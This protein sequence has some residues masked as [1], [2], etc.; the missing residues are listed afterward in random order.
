MK[1]SASLALLLSSAG[2]AH[3]TDKPLYQP[4]P[5]WVKPAPVPDAKALGD[6][7]PVFLIADN[8]QR[9]ADGVVWNYRETATRAIS[10]QALA[11]IG[12]IKL[13]WQPDHGDIVIHRVDILRDGERIDLL[14][15]GSRFTVLRREQ[16]LEQLQMDGMLTATM[17]VEGLRI[18]DILDV[19]FSVTNKDPTLKG[20]VQTAGPVLS[21]P[22]KVGF[23]RTR[24]LW[25]D[26]T[27]VRWKAYPVGAD[28][29]ASDAG[30]WHELTFALPVA[31]Q[32]EL[33]ADV[34]LRFKKPP[35]VEASS[36][37]G[38]EAVSKVM[39]PLYATDGLIAPGSPLAGEVAT[40]AAATPDPLHRAALAL[41]L[42]QAKV[43][44]LFRGMDNGNY[45]PQTP[46][47]TW[48]LRYGDCKAKTLLLLA[49]LHELK[50]DAEPVLANLDSGGFVAER[51]PSPGAF[52]H[53]LV[54]ATIGDRARWLDGTG[55]G[56]E[57][58]DIADVPA[59]HWVLPLRT[60]G[61]ALTPVP[62][63]VHGR[64]DSVAALDLDASA[65]LDLPA[66]FQASVT[67]HGGT[68]D[69]LRTVAA[70]AGK[71]DRDKFLDNFARGVPGAQ[72][73][74]TRKFAFDTASGSATVTLEGVAVPQWQHEDHRY[75]FTLDDTVKDL[76]F[77]PD[78]SRA[79]WKDLPVSIGEPSTHVTTIRLHLPD[80]GKG[81]ALEGDQALDTSLAGR[82]IQ[83]KAVMTA[84]LVT[85]D[86]KI[87]STGAEIPAA[88]IPATR[89]RLA[90]AQTRTLRVSSAAGYPAPWT[91][92]EAAKRAHRFDR[93]EALYAAHIADKP[94]EASR[95]LAR[96]A[97][98]GGIFERQ[99]ALDD[100][101][102]AIGIEASAGA[103]LFRA[104]MHEALGRPKDAM[105]DLKAALDLEPGSHPVIERLAVL[106]ADHGGK[107]QALALVQER[108]D[109]G[110]SD[111]ADF[112]ETKAE[113]LAHSGDRD[114]AL[115]AIDG[116]IEIKPGNASFLNE[117]CWI[118]A[119]LNVQLDTALKDCTRSIELSDTNT[120]AA[121]DSRAMTYFRMARPQEAL[122]DLDAAIDLRPA[123]AESLFMRGIVR[124]RGG[125][126]KAAAADLA[127]ARLLS[128]QVDEE[129]AR[130]GIKP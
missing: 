122:A 64:P 69:L 107:D 16:Q 95:Y 115:A 97:F 47:Q 1:R 33:P 120:G 18:G 111:K 7:A 13:T 36:F 53:I 15:A 81:F 124:E 58:E 59:L 49:I 23:A 105:A 57:F 129:Y 17:A 121:L 30:G 2:V 38:W 27:D 46:A 40:I 10:A 103:Y 70:Q 52:N 37:T 75:R 83:R 117:R 12:T 73:V 50:I 96:A 68:A 126:R 11:Q 63:A 94:D 4:A 71:E 127:A 65:G 43:R 9:L 74:A 5:A 14:K 20:N 25:P 130:Y 108:I 114:G 118:K 102:K 55:R 93:T 78:R 19:A 67:L 76:H 109:Q 84:G 24:L 45:L 123:S 89:A 51:L 125:D 101:D 98:F 54:R 42:V 92:I 116:A 6:D 32:P 44:Y 28:A 34:P 113:V 90:A 56:T 22:I 39:A 66:P 119:T 48:S 88:D 61:A 86:D 104:A 62:A 77:T 100:L 21:Q 87:A 91:A 106:Q 99:K 60:A 35:V 85:V 82:V 3:A 29:K 72:F 80:D 128:P 26:A 112:L 31:K 110:G 8:Q 79:A 41:A